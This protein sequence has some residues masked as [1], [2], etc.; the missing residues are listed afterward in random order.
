MKFAVAFVLVLAVPAFAPAQIL[1][2]DFTTGAADVSASSGDPYFEQYGTMIGGSRVEDLNVQSNPYNATAEFIASGGFGDFENGPGM[3]SADSLGWGFDASNGVFS[4]QH[5][6]D[7]NFSQQT[8]LSMTFA[9]VEDPIGISIDFYDGSGN[10]VGIFG[11]AQASNTAQT[12]TF[13][14]A[15][16]QYVGGNPSFDWGHIAQIGIVMGGAES[17][18]WALTNVSAAP[19]PTSFALLSLALAGLLNR[20]RRAA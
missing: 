12:V 2:D 18:D 19:E 6:I 17:A 15:N 20:R 14:F 4:G 10:A 7:A 8:Y 16:F 13:D 5:D 3:V 9:Y 1:I 11:T